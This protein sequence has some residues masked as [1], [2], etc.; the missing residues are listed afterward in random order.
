[1]L[2][3]PAE[4]L[5]KWIKSGGLAERY[6]GLVEAEIHDS[7]T[8]R[9][10]G[11]NGSYMRRTNGNPVLAKDVFVPPHLVGQLVQHE[12]GIQLLLRRNVLQR[13]ARIVQR[14]RIE[15]GTAVSAQV[16]ETNGGKDDSRA[17]EKKSEAESSRLETIVDSEVVEKL[18]IRTPQK[19]EPMIE[20][21]RKLSQD[22]SRRTTPERSWRGELDSKE[23]HAQGLEG[24]IT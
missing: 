9:Q 20:I 11:E 21:R 8:R 22:D 24:E 2:P 3:S 12:F 18:E 15:G 14:F 17:E 23:E 13:F 7:L 19:S 4:E 5:E 1:M 16:K 6:A 10:R